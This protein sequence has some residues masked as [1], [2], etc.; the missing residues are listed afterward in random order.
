[1]KRILIISIIILVANLL[2]GLVITAYSP[3]NLLFTS[4]AIVI[5]T[6]L[7]AFAFVG[8][9]E[10]THRLSWVLYLQVLA[11]SNLLQVSLHLNNGPTTGGCYAQSF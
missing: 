7:L 4:M 11:P 1:M 3:L 8:R 5:N 9:A 2:A 6:M 10:S